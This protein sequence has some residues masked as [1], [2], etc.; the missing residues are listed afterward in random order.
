MA[1]GSRRT[2]TERSDVRW[3]IGESLTLIGGGDPRPQLDGGQ[4]VKLIDGT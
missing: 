4:T 2:F 3:R 1:D